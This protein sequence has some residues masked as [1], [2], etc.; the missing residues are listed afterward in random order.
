MPDG[1]DLSGGD[2][3]PM[4]RREWVCARCRGQAIEGLRFCAGCADLDMSERK[5]A[6]LKKAWASVPERFRAA[7]QW[8]W[9]KVRKA[10]LDGTATRPGNVLFVGKP[11]AGKTAFACALITRHLR[12]AEAPGAPWANVDDAAASRYVTDADLFRAACAHPLG[13]GDPPL[14]REMLAAPLLVLDELGYDLEDRRRPA[15]DLLFARY[16]RGRRTII[17]TGHSQASVESHWGG[18][19]GRRIWTQSWLV[20]LDTLK[21]PPLP[22]HR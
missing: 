17:T 1:L 19:A 2:G 8:P 16:D 7:D 21:A 4:R 6:K 13:Q 9:D 11:G 12:A 3:G 14:Y 10:V 18:G 22:V 15:R 5:G 20:D